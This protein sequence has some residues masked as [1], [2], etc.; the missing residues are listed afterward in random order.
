[1]KYS[2]A[3]LLLLSGWLLLQMAC[4]TPGNAETKPVK[5]VSVSP[6]GT[7]EGAKVL[8]YHLNNGHGTQ[9]SISS[10]GGTINSWTFPDIDGDTSQII[11]GFD[12]LS[13]YL[14]HPPYFGALIGRYAN[15]IAKGHFELDGKEY[16]LA[17]ND[18]PNHLHGGIKGFDKVL[19]Q[20]EVPDSSRSALILK[21]HSKDGEEGYPGNLSVTVRYELSD[22]N[23]LKITYDAT[24]DKATPINLTNHSYFN[25]SGDLSKTVLNE[26]LMIHAPEYSPVVN[27]IPEGMPVSV[28]GTPFDFRKPTSIGSRIDQVPGGYDHNYALDTKGHLDALAASVYDSTT[29]RL[30]EVY[31]TQ[32]GL[33]FYSGNFLDGS[34]VAHD[35]QKVIKY[36]GLCLETQHFPDSPN[37][38]G[39]PSTILKPGD[40]YH[41]VAIYKLSL[42]K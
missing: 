16:Q 36:A 27:Q 20:V 17:V 35:Q 39:F 12:S 42:K 32:P 18:G 37:Q 38:P 28:S 30:L 19:W 13:T 9:I 40:T 22:D 4:Q 41:E 26:V 8:N 3:S 31:T 23:S 25:L 10:Y 6:W 24:T 5:A 21:Y 15:R 11:I 14:S 1:M 2:G 34:L 33:Q 7:Y 29:G